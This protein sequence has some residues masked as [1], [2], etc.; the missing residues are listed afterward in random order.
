MLMDRNI[1]PLFHEVNK[2]AVLYFSMGGN[3]L[4]YMKYGERLRLARKTATGEKI[5][6]AKLAELARVEQSLISQLEN[7]Q[8][9]E[10][11]QYTNRLA[12]ALGISPDWLADE[13]GEMIPVKTGQQHLDP[14]I[15]HVCRVMQSLPPY[16]V[17]AGVREIDSLAELIKHIPQPDAAARP[18][19]QPLALPA[20]QPGGG[21][22]FSYKPGDTDRATTNPA[23]KKKLGGEQ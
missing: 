18:A 14:R 21:L 10:G 8:T 2:S 7:S 23:D 12:R 20:P 4:V 15:E 11:S 5:S 16:A 22:P 17:D 9:A 1:S 6:Q 13:E 19:R 3:R